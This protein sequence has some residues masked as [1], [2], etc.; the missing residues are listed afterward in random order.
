[1]YMKLCSIEPFN[2]HIWS[3]SLQTTNKTETPTP[4]TVIAVTSA[5][6]CLNAF[7]PHQPASIANGLYVA[8]APLDC[9]CK[10]GVSVL[11][12]VD[13]V[14]VA[15]LGVT[16]TKTRVTWVSVAVVCEFSTVSTDVDKEE[17]VT[18]VWEVDGEDEVVED[19]LEEDEDEDDEDEEELDE[20]MDEDE[21][22]EEDEVVDELELLVL[23]E[24]VVDV[25]KVDD[26]VVLELLVVELIVVD[27]IELLK[28]GGLTG[29][30]SLFTIGTGT[31][32][33]SPSS[34]NDSLCS[35][36]CSSAGSI[37][38]SHGDSQLWNLEQSKLRLLSASLLDTPAENS[39]GKALATL[40]SISTL[41]AI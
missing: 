19:D 18:G 37:K 12:G 39:I 32:A 25:F 34:L 26:V 31:G 30:S 23:E 8:A 21:V 9:V 5:P 17:V 2:W 38:I 22:V 24:L 35:S 20:V 33:V 14:C 10:L 41:R 16:V 28:D 7:S 3:Q 4:N 6:C 29:S 27:D 11:V 1:M 13:D 15:L 36:S 40:A